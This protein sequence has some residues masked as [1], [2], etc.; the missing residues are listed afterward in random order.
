[1]LLFLRLLPE[2]S[3]WEEISLSILMQN[4]FSLCTDMM[5]YF[6]VVIQYFF[7][8]MWRIQM[9][10]KYSIR[11]SET[12]E[13]LKIWEANRVIWWSRICFFRNKSKLELGECNGL[14]VPPYPPVVMHFILLSIFFSV[15]FISHSYSF[16]LLSFLL[17]CLH[18]DA[19]LHILVVK[20]ITRSAF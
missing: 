4:Q 6:Q 12:V 18:L 15:G 14:L 5:H 3:T 10:R 17:V 19:A 16:I 8:L 7:L 20:P 2:V 1:M 11:Y 13:G 9:R